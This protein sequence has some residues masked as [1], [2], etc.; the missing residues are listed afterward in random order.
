M[1]IQFRGKTSD[2]KWIKGFVQQ[3]WNA[4]TE[5]FDKKC[6]QMISKNNGLAFNVIPDT[7]GQYVGLKDNNGVEIYEGDLVKVMQIRP[8]KELPKLISIIEVKFGWQ[9]ETRNDMFTLFNSVD[10]LEVIGNIHDNPELIKGR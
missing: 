5:S 4:E 3:R 2:G 6:T 10:T 8:H 1:K 9:I 7:V